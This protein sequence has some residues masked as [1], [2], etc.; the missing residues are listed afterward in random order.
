[1]A[2]KVVKLPQIANPTI[3]L[4]L[5]QFLIDQGHRL[6]PKPRKHYE[7]AIDL[8]RQ[9]L[10]NYA[11]EGL[12]EAE[13]DLF[14]KYFNAEGKEHREFC[15]LFGPE[16]IIENLGGFLGYF[17]IRKVVAGADLK[18]AA[19]SVTKK[20]SEWLVEK[21]HVSEES[22]RG[23]TKEGAEAA[24]DLPRAERVAQI[25]LEAADGL[26]VDPRQF[27]DEDYLD[28]DHFVIARIE[29][30]KLWFGVH[31]AGNEQMIGP[32]PVPKRATDVLREG[33]EI[34]CALGRVRGQWRIVEVGNVYPL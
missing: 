17:M 15:E 4:V 23:G 11:Y 5:D 25:L 3:E 12:P 1:M 29:P 6:K 21:G 33:W 18:R 27:D 14:K 8:L 22:G 34:S 9:H 16:K 10:N 31:E 7:D 20:L 19:G 32:V 28:F 26:A 2:A 13:A 30:G 24:H